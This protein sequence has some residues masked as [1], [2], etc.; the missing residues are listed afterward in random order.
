MASRSRAFG[1]SRVVPWAF[2]AVLVP[3]VWAAACGSEARPAPPREIVGWRHV[4]SWS[5]RGDAHTQNFTSDT[6]KFRVH[7]EAKNEDAPGTG[8]LK[9]IFRSGDSGNPIMEAANHRGAG[10]DTSYVGEQPRWYYLTIES[11]NV[12]WSVTVEE[13]IIGIRE[14]EEGRNR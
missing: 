9:V 6:G 5:G 4:G 13:P 12:D 10:R 8:T 14:D 3:A 7:W 1:R 2:L 11:A